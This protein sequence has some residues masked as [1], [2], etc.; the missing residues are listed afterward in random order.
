LF[1]DEGPQFYKAAIEMDP[2][3]GGLLLCELGFLTLILA[4]NK[5]RPHRRWSMG[6]PTD[7]LIALLHAKP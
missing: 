4:Q 6:R 2:S 1:A 5:N 3:D 7:P